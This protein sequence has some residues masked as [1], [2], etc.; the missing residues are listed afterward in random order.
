[1]VFNFMTLCIYPVMLSLKE[2]IE[3]ALSRDDVKAIVITGKV[4]DSVAHCVET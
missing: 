2:D 1:M 3:R 4:L